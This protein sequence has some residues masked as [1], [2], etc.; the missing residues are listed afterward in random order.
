MF[1]Q[2]STSK[3]S[4]NDPE[5]EDDDSEAEDQPEIGAVVVESGNSGQMN[6]GLNWNN[7]GG[8][9][10]V[11]TRGRRPFLGGVGGPNCRRLPTRGGGGARGLMNAD[12]CNF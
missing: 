11:R 2:S 6:G 9:N 4:F 10:W 12:V 3:P 1:F 5:Y 7:G 8:M